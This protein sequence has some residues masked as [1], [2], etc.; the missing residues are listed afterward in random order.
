[1]LAVS[2]VVLVTSGWPVFLVQER[3]GAAGRRI[4]I[5]KFRTMRVGVPVVAKALLEQKADL[6]TPVGPALRRSSLDELPQLWNVV[7]GE[8]SLIGPRPERPQVYEQHCKSIPGY[9]RRFAVRPGLV[10]PSQLFTPH[11]THK[12]I[13]TW[14]DNVWARGPRDS[15]RSVGLV[16]FTALIVTWKAGT[17]LSAFAWEDVVRSKVLRR[18]REKRR[19][20]RV[21]PAGVLV[22]LRT[23]EV[24]TWTRVRL[25]DMN[26]EALLVLTNQRLVHGT[27]GRVRLEIHLAPGRVGRRVRNADCSVLVAQQRLSGTGCALV[28]QYRP[29]TPRSHYLLHQYCLQNSLASPRSRARHGTRVHGE[30]AIH[31]PLPLEGV[32][33]GAAAPPGEKAF[34][35][36]QVA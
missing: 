13:R 11:G 6:Y 1:M 27:T 26:E 32:P 22:S 9:S 4:H 12:R 5:I 10:G 25:V 36:S 28:L 33:V 15:S 7:R 18:Y 2:V 3:V 19:L 35:G 17:R 29:L 23:D 24:R 31:T 30:P 34:D 20:R 14:I 16:L 21:K 8:M